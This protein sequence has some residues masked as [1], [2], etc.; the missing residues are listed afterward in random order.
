MPAYSILASV[1]LL[2]SNTHLLSLPPSP[3]LPSDIETSVLLIKTSLKELKQSSPITA[4]TQ[5][6]IEVVEAL[7]SQN[8]KFDSQ[9]YRNILDAVAKAG[10]ACSG[11][12]TRQMKA[13]A[14]DLNGRGGNFS[15]G[16]SLLGLGGR[17][18]IGGLEGLDLTLPFETGNF[19]SLE[20]GEGD[21]DDFF[22]SLGFVAPVGGNGTLEGGGTDLFGGNGLGWTNFS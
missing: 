3:P 7:L 20:T 9:R 12:E 8:I 17:D 6:G 5:A 2:L 22:R 1:S 11:E 4:H 16:M 13:I 14:E 19:G 10:I 18:V 15:T 21:Y